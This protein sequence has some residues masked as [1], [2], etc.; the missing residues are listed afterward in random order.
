MQ[1][2]L[3]TSGYKL[4]PPCLCFWEQSD[5]LKLD[6][7][8]Q[9]LRLAA[10]T[11]KYTFQLAVLIYTLNVKYILKI[12]SSSLQDLRKCHN[13]WLVRDATSL[14]T[15]FKYFRSVTHPTEKIC[16]RSKFSKGLILYSSCYT[17]LW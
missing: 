4:K 6:K 10:P 1:L 15:K 7:N 13:W 12:S 17:R 5:F 11:L 14:I 9:C 3:C 8:E 16:Q 2:S